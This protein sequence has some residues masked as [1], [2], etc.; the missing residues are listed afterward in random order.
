MGKIA[1]ALLWSLVCVTISSC[2]VR[3][4]PEANFSFNLPPEMIKPDP[5]PSLDPTNKKTMGEGFDLLE[6]R[7][8]WGDR[9]AYRESDACKQVGGKDCEVKNEK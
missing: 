2:G 3:P 5:R 8:L 9:Q 4:K 6:N 7:L 1:T